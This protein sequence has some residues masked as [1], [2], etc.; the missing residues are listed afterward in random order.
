M[1]I[2]YAALI[3]EESLGVNPRRT[4]HRSGLIQRTSEPTANRQQSTRKT[5]A[6]RDDHVHRTAHSRFVD[7]DH[8][9]ELGCV[10]RK[11]A[12]NLSGSGALDFEYD[13]YVSLCIMDIIVTT[14]NIIQS[15]S[16]MSCK[17]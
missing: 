9:D 7:Q 17:T 13:R 11:M 1:Y 10:Y 4:K 6:R 3:N 12:L 16:N 8:F 14:I 5:T 2:P 15:T